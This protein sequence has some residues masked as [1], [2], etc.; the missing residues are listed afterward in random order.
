M[1]RLLYI[2]LILLLSMAIAL[3]NSSMVLA[4]GGED[5]HGENTLE[6][7]V[8]GYH[9]TLSSQSDWKKGE[10][11]V[12]VTLMDSSGA[13]VSD[14]EV[15]IVIGPQSEEHAEPEDSH[16]ASEP[17][18]AHGAEQGHSN[19]P[20]MEMSGH[21]IEPS[22]TSPHDE[23]AASSIVAS[24][25]DEAGVYIAEAHLESAGKQEVNVMFHVN[26]EMLQADFIV[27]I[28]GLLSKT[29]VL[30]SFVAINVVLIASAGVMKK[31]SL[32][33]KGQ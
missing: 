3:T 9:V 23:E 19:M 17:P 26:G 25:T 15:E 29:I 2:T 27:K 13:P 7:E 30:W 16:V 10:N 33:V 5:E 24:E 12:V 1:K 28:P 11:I 4:D 22:S 20:G 31:Q 21:A 32:A 14:A 18:S 8:H 6:V